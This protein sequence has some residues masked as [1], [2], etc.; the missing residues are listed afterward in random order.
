[1]NIIADTHTHT[2]AS[3][4]AFST[5]QEMVKAAADMNLYAIGWT[6][7]GNAMPGAPGKWFFDSLY[8]V[9]STLYGVRVLKGIEA[10]VADFYGNLDVPLSLQQSLEWVV[11]SMHNV[12]LKG[13]PSF[14]K[15]TNAWLKVA[16]NPNVNVIGH[17]GTPEYKYD[18]E[19]VIPVF[20]KNGKLIEINNGS[21]KFR[22]G[23]MPNCIEIAKVCKKYKAPVVVNTDAHFSTAVGHA[24]D[25]LKVLQDIDFPKELIVN[26]QE[27][28]FKSY[29]KVCG[30]SLT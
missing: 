26:L 19:K 30:I 29:L 7:H 4:H 13:E 22:K 27:E 12:T 17:S 25:A 1:M 11:A 14:E 10:N 18:Y 28:T 16:E 3:T 6:D 24:D 21:F 9:P 15:C 2:L 8:S 20:A 5:I 23:S